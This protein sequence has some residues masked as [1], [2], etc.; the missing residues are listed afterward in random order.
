M[1]RA[2]RVRRQSK[3]LRLGSPNPMCIICGCQRIEALLKIPAK[4]L[5]RQLFEKHH[6][7]GRAAG[8]LTVI[9][10]RNCHALLTDWQEDWNPKL[11]HPRTPTECLAALLQGEADL[12]LARA[13]S[14]RDHAVHLQAWVA[15]LLEGMPGD[16]PK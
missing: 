3:E 15:W 12:D 13:Q 6:V 2:R 10:C 16:G 14:H 4:Q 1:D 11:R 8:R 7:A 9:V 5:P